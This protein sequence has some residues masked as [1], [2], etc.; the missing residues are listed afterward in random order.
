MRSPLAATDSF[1]VIF[2]IFMKTRAVAGLLTLTL[3]ARAIAALQPPVITPESGLVHAPALVILSNPNPSGVIFYTVDDL[4]PRDRFGNVSR[5]ARVYKRARDFPAIFPLSV[6]RS[7]VVRARVKA[8]AEWS[9]AVAAAFTADQDFSKLLFTEISYHGPPASV[10]SNFLGEFVELKNVGAV[11]LDVSGLELRNIARTEPNLL[12]NFPAGTSIGPGEFHFLVRG[13]NEFALVYPGVAV[14]GQLLGRKIDHEIGEL[15]VRATNGAIATQARFYSHAP[16]PVVPDDHFYFAGEMGFTLVRT[17]YDTGLD[18]RDYRTWQPSAARFGSPRADD[19]PAYRPPIV[20]NEILTRTS[21]GLTDSVELF[22]PTATDVDL[23]GW[24]LSDQRNWPYRYRIPTNTIIPA[25]GYRVFTEAD[26]N[27]GSGSNA[28]SFSAE[29]ER[30]YIFS[31]DTNGNLTGYSHGFQFNGSDRD[32]SFGRQVPSTGADYLLPLSARSFGSSNGPAA[33]PPLIISEFVY[34]PEATNS[35]FVELHNTLNVPLLLND[36]QQP[37]NSWA[38]GDSPWQEFGQTFF[39]ATNTLIPAKGYLLLVRGDTNAFRTNYNVP[40]DVVVVAPMPFS[41]NLYLPFPEREDGEKVLRLYKP[42][43]TP[44][45]GSTRYVVVDEVYYRTHFPWDPGASGGGSAL[46]RLGDTP[47]GNDPASWRASLPGG[48][49]GRDNRT[50]LAPQV[51]AGGA[52][53]YFVGRT[54]TIAGEI[55]DDRWPG[56]VL[57]S[58]WTQVSGP[59]AVA[60]TSNTLTSTCAT[61]MQTGEY[62]LRRSATDG[63]FTN[64]DEAMF[65]IISRP[66]DAWRATNFTSAELLDESISGPAADPD[67]DGLPNFEEYFFAHLPK[68]YDAASPWRVRIINN[69]L[70]IV[71]TQRADVPDVSVAVERADRVEGPWFGGEGLVEQLTAP[72]DTPLTLEVASQIRLPA[73]SARSQ[74][75]RMR[76]GLLE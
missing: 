54:L 37:T 11:A 17:N 58:T 16:W 38:L 60:F 30:C 5:T 56:T 34:A 12:Y 47:F 28:F 57:T 65:H 26:F 46:E 68:L 62:A 8:G 2:C 6:N 3:A 74:F 42:S 15:V 43:G 29:G 48:S 40:A 75:L 55:F 13:T 72:G 20:V 1:R 69:H 71:W 41:G 35:D 70:Q 10:I 44:S 27:V 63:V 14:D 39:F 33:P 52:K 73:V 31:G 64:S 61:F 45:G 4:D 53:T 22:N 21:S 50:N 66:F 49:P 76:L 7:M 9:E 67:H 36:P 32:V 51:W 19:P 25:L 59:A 18:P 24:W 23:G